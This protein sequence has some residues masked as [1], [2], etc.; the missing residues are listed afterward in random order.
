MKIFKQTK[1]TPKPSK[2]EMAMKVINFAEVNEMRV[3][4]Y[5]NTHLPEP[6]PF[7]CEVDFHFDNPQVHWNNQTVVKLRNQLYKIN[8]IAYKLPSGFDYFEDFYERAFQ[9]CRSFKTK[10]NTDFHNK[11]GVKM[12]DR[13]YTVPGLMVS[14]DPVTKT[15]ILQITEATVNR[16]NVA[17]SMKNYQKIDFELVE[18]NNNNLNWSYIR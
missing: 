13:Y 6:K 16:D 18:T 8:N 15:G 2:T 4:V 11:L 7:V 1:K 10:T 9:E 17:E 3:A 12:P 5:D 14:Y